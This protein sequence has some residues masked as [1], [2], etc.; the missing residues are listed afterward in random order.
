MSGGAKSREKKEPPKVKDSKEEEKRFPQWR[1]LT[2][3]QIGEL[4]EKSVDEV[5]SEFEEILG[6]RNQQ[7][8]MKEAALLDYYVCGFWRA[9]EA[10]F[11]PTQTSF[12]MAV[13]H[14]LLDNI[15]E[16]Q[17]GFVDNLMEFSKALAAARQHLASEG[18]TAPLL[19]REQAT[20]LI[21]YIRSSL[22]HKYRLYEL[23]FTTAREE[24][25]IGMERTLEVISS[26]DAFAP[27]EEGM[28]ADLYF[29]YL[30]LPPIQ[31]RKEMKQQESGE[32][33]QNLAQQME[34]DAE[35]KKEEEGE[36]GEYS[37]QEVKEVLGEL[38][39]D[40]LGSLQ[41]E[42]SEKLRLQE[43]SYAARIACLK[44]SSAK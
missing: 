12:T 40:M 15:R 34:R 29:R 32:M 23:L 24:L 26:E 41:A 3:K 36:A 22:F 33:H 16:K 7:T 6:F 31:E 2:H 11:T 25:L 30:A 44:N 20:V 8:C 38:A 4:L 28:S 13:L 21:D 18:D 14:M 27:L 9:K 42:F 1:A 17:M 37:V 35:E 10:D 43:E 39:K 19:D 5:Q